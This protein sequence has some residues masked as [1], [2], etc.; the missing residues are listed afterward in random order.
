MISQIFQNFSKMIIFLHFS[1]NHLDIIFQISIAFL[2]IVCAFETF[3]TIFL[4]YLSIYYHLKL[5]II[6]NL[7]FSKNDHFLTKI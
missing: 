4:N 2:M 7:K 3:K 1:K 6:K 5:I